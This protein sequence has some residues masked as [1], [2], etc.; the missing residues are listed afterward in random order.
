MDGSDKPQCLNQEISC[1]TISYIIKNACHSYIQLAIHIRYHENITHVE[2]CS[3]EVT[4]ISLDCFVMILG[5]NETHKPQVQFGSYNQSYDLSQQCHIL[6][7]ILNKSSIATDSA[8]GCPG[9]QTNV[10]KSNKLIF[11]NLKIFSLVLYF[12]GQL[13]FSAENVDFVDFHLTGDASSRL[14]C[15]FSCLFC[16]FSINQDTTSDG[17]HL[18]GQI[19]L[20][21][22]LCLSAILKH[23]SVTHIGTNF[24][25]VLDPG[26]PHSLSFSQISII[27]C[28]VKNNIIS[29]HS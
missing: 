23:S 24:L 25:N 20:S 22:C 6:Q 15:H 13:D 29:M 5:E 12:H 9:N 27:N 14:A 10:K 11:T 3:E 2:P 7:K 19:Q 17:Y 4:N 1:K 21:Q 8:S 16:S 26:Q 28:S 18:V